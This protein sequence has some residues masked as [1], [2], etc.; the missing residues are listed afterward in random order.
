[1]L[2]ELLQTLFGEIL[3]GFIRHVGAI[4]RWL[5]LGKKYSY[6][7]IRKQ[8]WNARVGILMV[9]AAVGVTI[10]ALL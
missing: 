4:V 5:F 2:D 8:D 6:R 10:F 7:E 9:L 1:M 3:M